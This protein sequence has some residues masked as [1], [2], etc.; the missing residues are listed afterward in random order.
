MKKRLF[1]KLLRFSFCKKYKKDVL[2]RF[3]PY[4]YEIEGNKHKVKICDEC[5]DER[6][7]DI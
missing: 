7:G 3:D 4:T 1:K 5:Y 2:V 6:A